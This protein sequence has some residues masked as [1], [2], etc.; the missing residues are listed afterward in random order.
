MT[1]YLYGASIQGIQEFIFQTD[2][3]VEI[4]GGSILVDYIC[5]E[6]FKLQVKACN[7]KEYE[8]SLIIGN[9]GIIKYK[10]NN[11]DS[12]KYLVRNFSKAV[13]EIAPGI[14]IS[15]AVVKY[16]KDSDLS[17]KIVEL[18][19]RL[20]IQRN[21][22]VFPFE[23]GYMGIKRNPRTGNNAVEE[24]NDNNHFCNPILKKLDASKPDNSVK[25]SL[26]SKLLGEESKF[27]VNNNIETI[28]K[29]SVYSWVAVIHA[30][31]NGL[32][33]IVTEL[34]GKLSENNKFQAFSKAIQYATVK[35]CQTAVK[36]T[37]IGTKENEIL[38]IRP[39]IIGGD[40]VSIVISGRYAWKFT[41]ELLKTFEEESAKLFSEIPDL[42]KYHQ[43]LT[44]CAG[45]AFIKSHFPLHNGLHL[46]EELCKD[47]KKMVK[48]DLF[49][50]KYESMPQSAIAIHKEQDS[51]SENL[52]DIKDS[53]KTKYRL[54]YYGGPYT[55]DEVASIT[56][57]IESF[58]TI[59]EDENSGIKKLRKL[60]SN[61]NASKE[62][63]LFDIERA[64][65]VSS[66]DF[67]ISELE[68]F[69][70]KIVSICETDVKTDILD[71]IDLHKIC[72]AK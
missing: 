56:S 50:K 19:K 5:T 67:I 65:E 57:K 2:K 11:E 15:Q 47:A 48:E 49:Q 36:N 16:E 59:S 24:D 64:I 13:S 72:Q 55:L 3:L 60:I 40:D 71:L 17:L 27:E 53:M 9:A 52:S 8:E 14:T 29:D 37:F 1:K 54:S 35:A 31:G 10:F 63:I 34:V 45:I 22:P 62:K 30:D 51:F 38:P 12:C 21:K 7:D 18:E 23:I 28:G 20:K 68:G 26:K 46:A 4:V 61:K 70:T 43:G 58:K 42:K 66:N 25:D 44:M 6:F 39:L 41:E 69:N 33:A 32:G